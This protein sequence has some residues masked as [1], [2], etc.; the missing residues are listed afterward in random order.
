MERR[1]SAAPTRSIVSDEIR[2]T[3]VPVAVALGLV[4]VLLGVSVRFEELKGSEI[5]VLLNKITGKIETIDQGGTVVYNGIAREFHALDRTVQTVEMAGADQLKVKTV[6]GGSVQLDL[7]VLYEL[8]VSKIDRIVADSGTG[9]AYKEKWVRDFARSICRYAFGELTTEGF[10]DA[11]KRTEMA[12]AARDR[13]NERLGEYGLRVVSVIPKDFTF[14]AEYEAKIKEKKLADQEVE[15]QVSKARAALQSMEKMKV[16]A[17]KKKATELKTFEGEMRELVIQAEGESARTRS[18]ADSYAARTKL[19]A[20]AEFYETQRKAESS[21]ARGRAEAEGMA[22][23]AAAL[24]GE[25]GRNLAKL[26]YAKRLAATVLS[27]Q[28]FTVSADTTRIQQVPAA[29]ALMVPPATSPA[30]APAN[31]FRPEV[32]P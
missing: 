3:L 26:E 16:E 9:D 24:A 5:G 27:G 14:Y 4:A 1:R 21:L 20:E 15:E 18:E 31:P 17:E 10:Y 19:A 22:R 28:P 7:T 29:A 32:R 13:L 12:L 6:D 11:G 23:M 30:A 2:R 8:D 25:G